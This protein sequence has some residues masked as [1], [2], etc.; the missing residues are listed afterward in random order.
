[1]SSDGAGGVNVT[2]TRLISRRCCAA[3]ASRRKLQINWKLIWKQAGAE[4][5]RGEGDAMR[6]EGER[7]L[8]EPRYKGIIKR[9]RERV[10]LD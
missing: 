6:S 8:Y 2:C 1:M 3:A 9:E 4:C 10:P 7:I 5:G